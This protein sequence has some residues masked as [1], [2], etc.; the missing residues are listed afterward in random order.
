MN[1]KLIN[2]ILTRFSYR[3]DVAANDHEVLAALER[4]P[5]RSRKTRVTARCTA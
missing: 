4:K 1:V 5:C 3:P 2:A